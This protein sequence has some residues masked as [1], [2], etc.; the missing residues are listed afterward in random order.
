[1]KDSLI[2]IFDEDQL[3]DLKAKV[4]SEDFIRTIASVVYH[5][6][7]AKADLSYDF[8][9][10]VNTILRKF[11]GRNTINVSEVHQTL[12]DLGIVDY[13]PADFAYIEET[14]KRFGVLVQPDQM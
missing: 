4:S 1:M 2:G 7:K 3:S 10:A 9:V 13:A 11:P 5:S 12:R 6:L 14:L 8:N